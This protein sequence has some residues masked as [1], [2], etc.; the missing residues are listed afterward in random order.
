M[1]Y[2]N[3]VRLRTRRDEHGITAI[4]TGPVAMSVIVDNES[5]HLATVEASSAIYIVRQ[6]FGIPRLQVVR[7][8]DMPAMQ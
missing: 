2:G 4:P 6:V 5:D 3:L 7:V 8:G 1:S